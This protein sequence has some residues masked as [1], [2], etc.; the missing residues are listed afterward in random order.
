MASLWIGLRR[1]A[2]TPDVVPVE[3]TI[4]PII[5]EATI[6]YVSGLVFLYK[7][8]YIVGFGLVEMTISTNPNSTIYREYGRAGRLLQDLRLCQILFKQNDYNEL[9]RETENLELFT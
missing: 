5:A 9:I 2:S 7:L 1:Y 4:Q 8:R 6:G 3:T